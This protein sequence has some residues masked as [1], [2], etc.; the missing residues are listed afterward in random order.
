MS[1]FIKSF[2]EFIPMTELYIGVMVFA[3]GFL[4]YG[5]IIQTKVVFLSS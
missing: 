5:T 1:R 3:S 2:H 4:I